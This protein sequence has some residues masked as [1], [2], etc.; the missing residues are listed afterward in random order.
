M[1]TLHVMEILFELWPDILV[2]TQA[3]RK[4]V[5]QSFEVEPLA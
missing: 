3:E 1:Q 2:L 5:Q 4:A